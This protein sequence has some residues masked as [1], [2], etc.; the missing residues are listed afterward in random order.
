MAFPI[1][2]AGPSRLLGCGKAGRRCAAIPAVGT[3]RPIVVRQSR[4]SELL[5][6]ADAL[7]ASAKEFRTRCSPLRESSGLSRKRAEASVFPT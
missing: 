4:P 6:D 5:D 7:M 3:L 1:G 2:H